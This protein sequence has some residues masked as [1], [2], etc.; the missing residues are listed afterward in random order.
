MK[1]K[2]FKEL[3]I[4]EKER[5][6]V[7]VIEPKLLDMGLIEITDGGGRRLTKKGVEYARKHNMGL[8]NPFIGGLS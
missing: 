8:S 1:K 2:K 3:T 6:I 7:E 5:Y 4:Q